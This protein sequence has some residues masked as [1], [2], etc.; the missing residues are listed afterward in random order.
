MDIPWAE[1]KED[2]SYQ[3][4]IYIYIENINRIYFDDLVNSKIPR[5]SLHKCISFLIKFQFKKKIETGSII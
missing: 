2:S 4:F 1:E 3:W 5:D